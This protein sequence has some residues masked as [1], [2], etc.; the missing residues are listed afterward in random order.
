M[1]KILWS[2]FLAASLATIGCGSHPVEIKGAAD[3]SAYSSCPADGKG[4]IAGETFSRQKNGRMVYGAGRSIYLD[5]ATKYSAAVYRAIVDKQNRSDFFKAEK[6]SQTVTPDPVILKCR[7]T[8]KAD[9]DGRFA[10]ENVAPGTWFVSSWISWIRPDGEGEWV[11]TW[12]VRSV[13]ITE[14]GKAV[15]IKL[16]GV[17][18]TIADPPAAAGR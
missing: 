9:A 7:R 6:E 11:G 16:S 15:D 10:F 12:N 18:E 4:R 3:A 13:V 8:I 2:S 5:P 17:P 14:D 1:K